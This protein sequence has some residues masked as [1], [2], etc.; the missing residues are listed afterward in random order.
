MI[1]VSERGEQW[2]PK[3]AP[4]RIDAKTEKSKGKLSDGKKRR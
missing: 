1:V 3:T 2:S 4:E